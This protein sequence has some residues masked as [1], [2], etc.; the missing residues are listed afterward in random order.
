MT[1]LEIPNPIEQNTTA[2]AV[3]VEQNY[4]VIESWINTNMIN[5]F[6]TVPMA[7]PLELSGDPT[8]DNQAANK[9]Y[10]DAVIPVGTIFPYGG[11]G[12][13]AGD[14]KLCNG[15]LL[16]QSTY[17]KLFGVLGTRY[18]TAPAGQFRVP[19][20]RGRIPIGAHAGSTSGRF[21]TTGNT[22]GSWTVPVPSHVHAIDHNHLIFDSG[23]QVPANHT[24]EHP[25]THPI[26]HNHASAAAT[27]TSGAGGSHTTPI[28]RRTG[29]FPAAGTLE[30]VIEGSDPNFNGTGVVDNGGVA[31]PA[32]THSLS[33]TVDLPAFSGNSGAVSE[34]TTGVQSDPHHHSINVPDFEGDSEA[35]SKTVTYDGEHTPPLTT[36]TELI[37]PFVVI[38]YI[39]RVD[40]T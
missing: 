24:H 7:N 5:R 38:N 28:R 29:A 33:L 2:D 11:N 9:N 30:F 31:V 23:N 14:W 6:G 35:F 40:A 36:T 27:G 1:S 3:E 12:P 21:D 13:P 18:G 10:V 15:Q 17:P 22:A 34:A 39:V 37:P 26:A 8:Q 25:H 16:P 19:D 4:S 32:H 20:L